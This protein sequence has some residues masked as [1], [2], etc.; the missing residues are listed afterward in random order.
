MNGTSPGSASVPFT[1]RESSGSAK[2]KNKS[3]MVLDF[4]NII[5]RSSHQET[6]GNCRPEHFVELNLAKICGLFYTQIR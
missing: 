2:G 6:Q 1:I 4:L 5:T 3:E